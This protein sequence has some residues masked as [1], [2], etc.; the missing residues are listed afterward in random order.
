MKYTVIFISCFVIYVLNIVG[1][2]VCFGPFIMEVYG[3]QESV[4]L[5]G[6]INGFSKF[7]D[8]ITTVSAFGFS[9]IC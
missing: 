4:I 3:I 8:I 5:G 6:I 9:L 1:L 7:S 2:A